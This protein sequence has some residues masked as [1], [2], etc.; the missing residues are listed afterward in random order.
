[1]ETSESIKPEAFQPEQESP[2]IPLGPVQRYLVE[3]HCALFYC[4]AG[5]VAMTAPHAGMLRLTLFSGE[6]PKLDTTAAVSLDFI[7]RA[8]TGV[9]D[10]GGFVFDTGDFTVTVQTQCFAIQVQDAQGRCVIEA[11]RL[12][13][14]NHGGSSM[15]F[16]KAAQAHYY[17]L[18]ESAG[19]LDKQG[20]SYTMWNSDVY[21]P[22][23]P[24]MESLYISIPLL[25]QFDGNVASGLFLDN[26]GKSRFD[27]R[28]HRDAVEVSTET[29][30][31][32]V[33]VMA[34]PTLKDVISRYTELTGRIPMPPKWAIGYHQSRYSYMNQEEVLDVA[35]TFRKKSI[36]LD[37]IYLDVHYMDGYRVFT[38]DHDRFPDPKAMIAALREMGVRIV[39]IVD[40]GVKQDIGYSMYREG[41]EGDLFCKS[42]EGEIFIGDVWPGPSAFPDFSDDRVG[43]WW[44]EHQK[45]YIDFGVSG[46]WNDM[47]E[48][49]VFNDI[50]TMDPQILHRNNGHPKSHRELHNLY[51]LWMTRATYQGLLAHMQGERPFVVTRAAYSGVQRYA[52]VWT[53]DNRSFWEHMA[54][55]MPMVLNMGMSGVAMAGPD[56]GGFAHHTSPELL[57]R[58]VQMGAFFPFFRN[59]SALG[60]V[61]QE[62]WAFGAD[63][64][65]ILRRYIMLR[66]RLMPYLYCVFHEAAVTGLPIVRPLVLEYPADPATYNL[67]DQFLVGRDLL[68]APVYRPGQ[69]YRMVYLPAGTWVNYWTEERL[70]GGSYVVVAADLDTLPLFVRAGAVIPEGPVQQFAY[71]P[72][73]DDTLIFHVYP[74]GFG[75]IEEFVLYEDDGHSRD[76]ESGQYNEIRLAVVETQ[77]AITVSVDHLHRGFA[78]GYGTAVI[79]LHRPTGELEDVR[80]DVTEDNVTVAFSVQ[81]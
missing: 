11:F 58:W 7:P 68:V 3:D 62:P 55:A 37:A 53:G 18:G 6:K 63:V 20:E 47:N 27:M 43:A 15:K 70:S 26:P 56:V 79:R 35:H 36:P 42:L 5:N 71:E 61:R 65:S 49:A 67:C 28:T 14:T 32:D 69:T 73:P 23:V 40:P 4:A 29:G 51:G 57:V 12:S 64:E 38:F 44:A 9:S 16:N 81:R 76:Y 22:H 21:A 19:Y 80:V 1:M 39:P 48:P 30:G 46:I 25:L 13:R 54:M 10:V 77:T 60:T 33:Y 78:N 74:K 8:I 31:V 41:V 59:H 50:K 17:G 45:F 34:G 24:E 2:K 72:T 66:Y 52:A 75:E